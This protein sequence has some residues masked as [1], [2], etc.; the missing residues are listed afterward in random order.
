MSLME[1]TQLVQM[2]TRALLG[3]VVKSDLRMMQKDIV[4]TEKQKL[5]TILQHVKRDKIKNIRKANKVLKM[6]SGEITPYS[7][8]KVP[9]APELLDSYTEALDELISAYKGHKAKVE[10]L[11]KMKKPLAEQRQNMLQA[12]HA[13]PE[14]F[15]LLTNEFLKRSLG[16]SEYNR[17]VATF[18]SD[19]LAA[20]SPED[21]LVSTTAYLVFLDYARSHA[22]FCEQGLPFFQ[23]K[24]ELQTIVTP[25]RKVMLV[26]IQFTKAGVYHKEVCAANKLSLERQYK[27][28]CYMVQLQRDLTW[29]YIAKIILCNKEKIQA[30]YANNS[31]KSKRLLVSTVATR[32]REKCEARLFGAVQKMFDTY[33]VHNTAWLRENEYNGSPLHALISQNVPI[34]ETNFIKTFHAE[35]LM[36]FKHV[37]LQNKELKH[38]MTPPSMRVFKTAQ[39]TATGL[40]ETRSIDLEQIAIDGLTGAMGMNYEETTPAFQREEISEK[41]ITVFGQYIVTERN[42]LTFETQFPVIQIERTL[43]G[44]EI[45]GV[46]E[47]AFRLGFRLH[48]VLTRSEK[49]NAGKINEFLKTGA[50]DDLCSTRFHMVRFGKQKQD[51]QDEHDQMLKEA[52]SDV[53]MNMLD[54]IFER[55]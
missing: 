1:K 48:C 27:R 41:D 54:E 46:N 8:R 19:S 28:Y 4:H 9:T 7:E 36:N 52:L 47:S 23:F 6:L 12:S 24:Q 15:L 14:H 51:T 34:T 26:N 49:V 30:I 35:F 37:L 39:K 17:K 21:L 16:C 20:S 45:V 3:N 55:I 10:Y 18:V 43:V 13:R 11:K 33:A 38:I 42:F 31:T 25:D 44:A 53:K 29:R 32:I 5:E 40:A 50:G 2:M 22:D